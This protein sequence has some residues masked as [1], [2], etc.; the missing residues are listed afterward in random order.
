MSDKAVDQD[1]SGVSDQGQA[2]GETG[3]SAKQQEDKVAYET[4]RKTVDAEKKAKAKADE[5]ARKLKEYEE[6]ELA[7]QGKSQELIE[8]L[9]NQVKEKE[10]K[11]QDVVGTF[12]YRSVAS[13]IREEALKQGCLDVDLLLKAG[14]DEFGKIEVDAEN[15]FSVNDSDL[16]NFFDNTMKKHP[17]LF[18]KAG[19][20]IHDSAP[21]TQGH[22]DGAKPKKTLDQMALEFAQ[23]NNAKQ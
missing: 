2:S 7:A 9:R 10:T 22:I 23:L 15:G 3:A 5:L 21:S 1:A 4:Y 11:L 20:K 13:K 17:M 8:S 16:K 14:Q 6:K 19:P 18:K 12:A